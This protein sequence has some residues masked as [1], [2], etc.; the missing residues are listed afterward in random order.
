MGAWVETRQLQ[1]ATVWRQQAKVAA[2]PPAPFLASL[3]KWSQPA[4]DSKEASLETLLEDRSEADGTLTAYFGYDMS[5][6]A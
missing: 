5:H 2:L 3:R 1:I 6:S 4:T